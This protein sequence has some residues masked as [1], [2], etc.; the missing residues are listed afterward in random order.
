MAKP[1][2]GTEKTAKDPKEE[3]LSKETPSEIT[4]TQDPYNR[5]P[6][7]TGQATPK[8]SMVEVPDEEDDTSFQLKSHTV[9]TRTQV[10]LWKDSGLGFQFIKKSDPWVNKSRSLNR[11][12]SIHSEMVLPMGDLPGTCTQFIDKICPLWED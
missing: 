9:S 3:E 8:V 12:R 5:S 10:D 2:L 4:W 1:P 11:S 7:R 6:G